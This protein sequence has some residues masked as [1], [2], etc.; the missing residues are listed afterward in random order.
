MPALEITRLLSSSIAPVDASLA[1]SLWFLAAALLLDFSDIS[2][3][4]GDSAGGAGALC[5]AALIALGPMRAALIAL[6]AAAASHV[7]RRGKGAPRRL[8]T[9]VAA[10]GVALLGGALALSALA[11]RTAQT[12]EFLVV[13]AVFLSVEFVVSQVITATGWPHGA[14]CPWSRCCF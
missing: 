12:V 10:R 4:R 6:V 2:L 3:P 1:A 13:P 5:S 14:S 7:L 11:S 9:V 8:V